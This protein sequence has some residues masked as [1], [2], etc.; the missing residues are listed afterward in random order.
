MKIQLP[1][2]ITRSPEKSSTDIISACAWCPAHTY[3][4]LRKNQQYTH[5]IC[6][7]HKEELIIQIRQRHIIV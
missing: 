4:K 7:R 3:R 1:T 6:V 5:G 2:L